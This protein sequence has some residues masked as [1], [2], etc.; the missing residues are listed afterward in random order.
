[1]QLKLTKCCLYGAARF[2]LVRFCA[3]RL[4]NTGEEQQ[5]SSGVDQC[6]RTR[7]PCII[8]S[9]AEILTAGFMD[10]ES[11]EE[12][13]TDCQQ[14]TASHPVM[15]SQHR[16]TSGSGWS[17]AE[18]GKNSVKVAQCTGVKP[19]S[20]EQVWFSSGSPRSL[21]ETE[22]SCW[23]SSPEKHLGLEQIF[24]PKQETFPRHGSSQALISSKSWRVKSVWETVKWGVLPIPGLKP[25]MPVRGWV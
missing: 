13:L 10:G 6:Y 7:S 11:Q 17:R 2:C 3:R 4:R 23:S 16:F 19:R 25:H 20:Q 14:H 8:K 18:P 22:K 5:V 9:G 24:T 21:W 1:M 15:R 12:P